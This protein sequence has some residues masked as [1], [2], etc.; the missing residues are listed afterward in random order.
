MVSSLTDHV[1]MRGVVKLCSWRRRPANQKIY[2]KRLCPRLARKPE[3]EV[4]V[5]QL[6][7]G[8]HVALATAS[9]SASPD[10]RAHGV[11]GMHPPSWQFTNGVA[12]VPPV[13]ARRLR[14]DGETR[15]RM[16]F[17]VT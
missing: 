14:V 12:H 10:R 15:R 7:H 16:S 5:G 6:R 17:L 1:R 4:V 3:F 13:R 2:R 8:N 9:R 11:T